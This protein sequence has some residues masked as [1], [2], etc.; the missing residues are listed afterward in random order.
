MSK[1]FTDEFK[2]LDLPI[3]GVRLPSFDIDV[4]YKRQNKVS[5][6]VDNFTFLKSIC[7]NGLKEKNVNKKEYKERLDYELKTVLDLGFTDYMLL[8][9]DVINFCRESNIPVGLGRGSAAGSLILFCINV[10]QIDPIK[11]GLFFERFIS[12]TRAKKK[13][14]DGVTYLDGALMCDVD[15][16]IC[17][18]R[19]PEV[20]SYLEEKFF[21]RTSKILTLNTLSGKLL[22]KESGKIVGQKEKIKSANY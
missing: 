13:V 21:G 18:Y 2:A 22:I 3:H 1:F 20:L 19:R 6:D 4:K 11:Y 9:W 15:L 10:T 12:K 16:D 14:V 7:L 5:E 17:Y 8:V